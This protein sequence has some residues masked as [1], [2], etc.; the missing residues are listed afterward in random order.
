LTLLFVLLATAS[1]AVAQPS[2]A[3]SSETPIELGEAGEDLEVEAILPA[4]APLGTPRVDAA[5]SR[6][7]STPAPAPIA[8]PPIPPPER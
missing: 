5:T 7:L 3:A 1:I 6:R 2:A 8:Q 4:A